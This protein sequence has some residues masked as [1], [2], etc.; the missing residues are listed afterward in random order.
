MTGLL[1][2]V[3]AVA[4]PLVLL[5]S[6]VGQLAR[7]GALGAALLTHRVVPRALITPVAVL[8]VLAE[9]LAGLGAA[10]GLVLGE[11]ALLRPALAA[12][13]VLLALY[14]LY[15]AHV[16]RTRGRVPC[17]CAGA[18]TPMTGWVA[19]RAAVLAALAA[20]GALWG[21]PDGAAGAEWAVMALAG[22]TLAALLW[23][24]PQA[25]RVPFETVAGEAR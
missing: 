10:A 9:A 24:L 1:G 11:G 2:G 16:A 22:L 12:G 6:L 7:P 21:P 4:V 5:V 18:A 23:A 15:G 14:A 3:A 20:A 13:A 8:A 19:G 17:G 25:M